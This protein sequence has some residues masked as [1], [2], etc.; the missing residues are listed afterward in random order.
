MTKLPQAQKG[1]EEIKLYTPGEAP[2]AGQNLR[3]LSSNENLYGPSP[4][5]IEAVRQSVDWLWKYPSVDHLELR[6]AI[7]AV[8]N[9]PPERLI[10]GAGSDEILSLLAQA[11]AGVGDEVIMTEH[12]FEIY[13]IVTKAVGA[14]LVT[15]RERERV[16]DVDAIL[17]AIN[18]KTRLIYIANPANPTGTML[19]DGE[20]ER[21]ATTIPPNVILVIDSA[22][23]EFAPGYDGGAGLVMKAENL[24]M[25]RTF[26]KLYGLGGLRVGWAFA[27]QAVIDNLNRI[28]GPFNL[29][30]PALAGAKSAMLDQNYAQEVVQNILEDRKYFR[31]ALLQFGIEVDESFANFLLLRFRDENEAHA[32]WQWLAQKGFLTRRVGHYGLP[33]A[34]R[35]TIGTSEDMRQVAAWLGEFMGKRS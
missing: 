34:L 4:Q 29:S 16:V 31:G 32:A 20:L 27:P 22:Y 2:Q 6:E 25:T 33:N 35:I 28:R 3:K 1:I 9:L 13:G 23:A 7:G 21:L 11:Y 12:G 10:C 26:S 24:V 15:V 18:S 8:Q 5:A 30:S 14:D 17:A 19:A